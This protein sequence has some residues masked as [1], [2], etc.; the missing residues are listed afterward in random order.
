MMHFY[1]FSEIK[2]SK[3]L[4]FL[5]ELSKMLYYELSF[6]LKFNPKKENHKTYYYTPNVLY[7]NYKIICNYID[8][9]EME[10]P[11]RQKIKHEIDYQSTSSQSQY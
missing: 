2:I 10:T 9:I 8:K 11:K 4:N 3:N 6:L 5:I 7:N 1:P